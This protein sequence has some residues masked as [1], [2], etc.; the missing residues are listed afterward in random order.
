MSRAK[1][2]RATG[3]S[4]PTKV[5]GLSE[6]QVAHYETHGWLAPIEVMTSQQAAAV[7]NDLERAERQYPDDLHAQHR[8]NAH[9]AFPFLAD[10]ATNDRIVSC[11]QSLLGPDLSLW[12]TVLFIKE[13][14]SS[15]YVSW[16]QDAYYMGLEPDRFV[17][18]WLAL[19]PSTLES[20]CVSVIP[21]SHRAR[22]DH[23]D[24][25]GPDNILTRGQ[26][27]DGVDATAAIHLEL[28]PG[29]M[30]LHHPWLTHGSQPNQSSRRRVGVAMQ[31]YLAGDV[32]PV[33][34]VHHVLPI[35]GKP[36]HDDFVVTEGPVKECSP[37]GR[38]TRAAAN[39][40]LADVLYHDADRTRAL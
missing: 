40:A 19:T 21:G 36:P 37:A 35:S 29:Q 20:G 17:T 12:S 23:T 16:H 3:E 26:E 11:V 2:N 34:G 14:G 4:G 7:L 5:P 15:S 24:T 33:R 28:A 22:A 6:T 38:S 1:G 18:A 27:V 31:S 32:R 39:A 10:V 8:N 13:P 9:L 25:F 30:S